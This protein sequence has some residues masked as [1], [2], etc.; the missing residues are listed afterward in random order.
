M[1]RAR[2]LAREV[3]VGLQPSLRL[4]NAS[5]IWFC[6]PDSQIARVAS[7]VAKNL[8]SAK[9][10]IAFHSSGALTSDELG[11][12]RR[13]GARVASV[14]PLMTFVAGSPPS[15]SSVPFAIE[16]DPGA[17]RL[18][19]RIVSDVGGIA[20]PIRKQHKIAYHAWGTFAS[21]LLTALLVTAE[22][23]A[24]LA[25]IS[26]TNSKKRMIPIVQQTIGNY[27]KFESAKAFSG[28]I[29]RGDVA[30]MAQHL[31]ALRSLPLVHDVY[32]ALARS[33]IVNLK[34]KNKT[35]MR[36]LLRSAGA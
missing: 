36:R 15:L 2:T 26:R 12:L 3:G 25:G 8:K 19:R 14:H 27:A 7:Q 9:G 32:L 21:P 28:P 30:I 10:L 4:S 16:G 23:V 13:K 33:A 6:V 17:V 20:Y 24:G 18:A 5:V 1:K 31:K 22:R 29:I 35:T 34:A 11:D